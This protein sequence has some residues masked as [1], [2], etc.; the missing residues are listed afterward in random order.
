METAPLS[1]HFRAIALLSGILIVL[2]AFQFPLLGPSIQPTIDLPLFLPLAFFSFRCFFA[3][4]SQYYG[5]RKRRILF[6][7]LG[8][9]LLSGLLGPLLLVPGLYLVFW[10]SPLLKAIF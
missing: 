7:V 8:A 4:F 6:V 9:S 3:A 5:V 10:A 2:L 1:H